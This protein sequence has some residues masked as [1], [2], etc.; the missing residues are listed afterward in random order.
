MPADGT[1]PVGREPVLVFTQYEKWFRLSAVWMSGAEGRQLEGFAAA[2][3]VASAQ[4]ASGPSAGLM[5]YV[6]MAN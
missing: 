5:T 2:P 3:G 4:T 1:D 6:V